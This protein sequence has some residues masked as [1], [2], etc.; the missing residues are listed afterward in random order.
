MVTGF[1]RFLLQVSCLDLHRQNLVLHTKLGANLGYEHCF[2]SA[3][4][5][6]LVIDRGSFDNARKCCIREEQEREAVRTAR[7]RD[8]QRGASATK[9]R[10]RP[11]QIAPEPLD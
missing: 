3:F 10:Q 1:P 9:Q 2:R 11:Q 7:N 4:A 6:Q 8:T 5:A